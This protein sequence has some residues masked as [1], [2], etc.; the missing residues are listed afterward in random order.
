MPTWLHGVAVEYGPYPSR[1][2]PSRHV[3]QLCLCSGLWSQW[4][5]L[6]VSVEKGLRLKLAWSWD[7][8]S[9]HQAELSSPETLTSR[10]AR[11]EQRVRSLAHPLVPDEKML[12][13]MAGLPALGIS[14]PCRVSCYFTF[15]KCFFL[16]LL[17]GGPGT[18]PPGSL[19]ES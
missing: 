16:S 3:L 19:G 9:C 8:W 15:I 5:F 10:P 13:G 6:L 4:P 2:Y 1:L 12:C 11:A 14:T 18:A 17:T 7:V